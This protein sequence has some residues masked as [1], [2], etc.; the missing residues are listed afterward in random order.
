MIQSKKG[1]RMKFNEKKRLLTEST[2][3]K[4]I[5]I[6]ICT[7]AS[8]KQQ[9]RQASNWQAGNNASHLSDN[10]TKQR[11]V[12]QTTIQPASHTASLSVSQLDSQQDD[13]PTGQLGNQP[14]RQRQSQTTSKPFSEHARGPASQP[15]SQPVQS[16]YLDG[17]ETLPIDQVEYLTTERNFDWTRGQYYEP[18]VTPCAHMGTCRNEADGACNA[19]GA[20]LCRMHLGLGKLHEPCRGCQSLCHDHGSAISCR[21]VRCLP[22]WSVASWMCVVPTCT[23]NNVKRRRL[24][25]WRTYAE[26]MQR[27]PS[28]RTSVSPR[29]YGAASWFIEKFLSR[30]QEKQL[31]CW[32]VWNK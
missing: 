29:A 17:L 6:P 8:K 18:S 19:C 10:P 26:V 31:P 12:K 16:A 22:I 20:P 3:Q 23:C 32:Y 30:T 24:G 9:V 13:Q 21:C 25:D 15:E 27:Q 1:Q 4:M 11:L 28:V 7:N 14:T 5:A 2:R